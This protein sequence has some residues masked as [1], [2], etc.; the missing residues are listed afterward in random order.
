MNFTLLFLPLYQRLTSLHPHFHLYPLRHSSLQLRTS[1]FHFHHAFSPFPFIPIFPIPP[2]H[3]PAFPLL[4]SITP[5]INF[6]S[7][8][9]SSY[10]FPFFTYPPFI[11]RKPCASEIYSRQRSL[12]AR[13]MYQRI[14]IYFA[15]EE[16]LLSPAQKIGLYER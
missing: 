7:F 13:I 11:P 9:F 8:Y 4:F 12:I 5:Y 16:V 15:L 3:I 14:Y 1:P 2:L 10:N 6:P